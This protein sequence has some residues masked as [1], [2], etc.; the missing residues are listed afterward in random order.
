[1]KEYTEVKIVSSGKAA[2]YLFKEDEFYY[3]KLEDATI[4][5]KLMGGKLINI[6]GEKLLFY[7]Q[8]YY[9]NLNINTANTGTKVELFKKRRNEEKIG[10]G[11]IVKRYFIK[12]QKSDWKIGKELSA[13]N[14]QVLY[15]KIE[16]LHHDKLN[17]EYGRIPLSMD[18][19]WFIY[20]EKDTIHFI[21]SWTGIE[22]FDAKLEQIDE[23]KWT[24]AVLRTINDEKFNQVNRLSDFSTLLESYISYLRRIM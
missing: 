6:E 4:N 3:F 17:L 14:S 20:M 18:D 2:G 21:R 23:D 8:A 10:E 22:I 9:E 12:A 19:K 24:I 15:P 16:L 7:T 11:I 13:H 5:F 1:M